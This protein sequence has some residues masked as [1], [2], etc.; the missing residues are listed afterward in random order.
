MQALR[1]FL[2][3]TIA[4]IGCGKPSS[5]PQHIQAWVD[6]WAE[7]GMYLPDEEQIQFLHVNLD[8]VQPELAA[9]LAHK[10][11][12]IRQRAAYVV[13]E[14]GPDAN[15]LGAAVFEQLKKEPKQLVQIYLIDAL[16]SIR[17]D[18]DEVVAYLRS[19]YDSLSSENTAAQLG[20][21]Y[22]EV[23]E[24]INLAGVLYVLGKP[25]TRDQYR[26]FVIQWLHPPN[27]DLSSSELSGYWERR[28]M[29]VNALGSM[30]GASEAIPLLESMLSRKESEAVVVSTCAAGSGRVA[31]T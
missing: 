18:N 20:G 30:E 28:W 16:G 5:P 25:E 17:F 26:D 31:A 21:A 12:D 11:P 8:D 27:E 19:K 13:G 1:F 24:K 22:A 29:A 6:S 7:M 23:D 14:I 4:I 3:T 15:A 9:A 10:N 2:L